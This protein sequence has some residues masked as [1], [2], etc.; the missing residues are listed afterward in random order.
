MS[1]KVVYVYACAV[2]EGCASGPQEN[3]RYCSKELYV[4]EKQMSGGGPRN[5]R[6]MGVGERWPI[7]ELAENLAITS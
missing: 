2:C 6:N 3:W 5:M 1:T 4:E 7:S